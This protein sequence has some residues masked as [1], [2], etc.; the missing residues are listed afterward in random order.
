MTQMEFPY[1][2]LL[3]E[4]QRMAQN[5]LKRALDRANADHKDWQKR[6]WELFK[7]WLIIKPGDFEFKVEDFRNW[8]KR[9]G[10]IEM[11]NSLRAFGFVAVKAKGEGLIKKIGTGPVSNED[12]HGANAGVWVKIKN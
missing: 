10:K 5:G 6:C 11:P 4:G 9:N 8:A 3:A 7:E 1:H 2:E 12:A